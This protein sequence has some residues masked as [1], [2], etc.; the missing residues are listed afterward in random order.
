MPDLFL[1][2]M[3]LSDALLVKEWE[4]DRSNWSVSGNDSDYSLDEIRSLVDSLKDIKTA[5]QAR[6]MIIDSDEQRSLGAIDLFDIDFLNACAFVGILVA[7][8]KDRNRGVAENA[9]RLLEEICIKELG[10][11]VL[12]AK[13]FTSNL[14]SVRL[15]EKRSFIKKRLM[16]AAELNN[17]QYIETQIF[18]KCLKN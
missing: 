18:E 5:K 4:N 11:D 13:V 17:G 1:R 7:K 9:L 16:P 12:Y 15:F 8:S 3:V 14:P 6:Y 10:I 2:P